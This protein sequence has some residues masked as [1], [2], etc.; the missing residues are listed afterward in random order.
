M[1]PIASSLMMRR[2]ARSGCVEQPGRRTA[3]AHATPT[4]A[5]DQRQLRGRAARPPRA[6]TPHPATTVEP[7]SDCSGQAWRSTRRRR[8]PTTRASQATAAL[9]PRN[10]SRSARRLAHAA[11]TP[12]DDHAAEILA[13]AAGFVVK[14]VPGGEKHFV[15]VCSHDAVDRPPTP[16]PR[17]GRSALVGAGVDNGAC[18]CAGRCAPSSPAARRRSSTSPSA[19]RCS[20]SRLC[21]RRPTRTRRER[22]AQTHAMARMVRHCCGAAL[23]TRG[24]ARRR[25]SSAALHAAA[26]RQVPRREGA[27]ADG[28]LG[29]SR[30]RRRRRRHQLAEDL[31]R[32]PRGGVG[33]R[34]A[35]K[36]VEL[37][38]AAAARRQAGGEKAFQL[39]EGGGRA[40]RAVRRGDAPAQRGRPGL[41]RRA[42]PKSTSSTRRRCRRKS[43]THDEGAR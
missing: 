21:R 1:K 28:E 23:G 12:T 7:A 41:A 13:P 6:S 11:S 19:R 17:G 27:G 38:G 40:T 25:R 3:L 43:R 16:R 24:G 8:V 9:W 35:P 33:V 10:A 14:V 15:N 5:A 2:E 34:P 18:R 32:W 30:R 26:Q 36:I 4:D 39:V 22:R 29:S 37:D 31:V 20:P 42:A